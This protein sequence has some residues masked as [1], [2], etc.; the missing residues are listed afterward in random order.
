VSTNSRKY[1]AN[2]NPEFDFNE[3]VENVKNSLLNFKYKKYVLI[4]SADVYSNTSDP[5]LSCEDSIIEVENLSRYGFHKYLAEL[6]VK[7]YASDWL[8]FRMGGFI[9]LGLKKNAIFDILNNQSMWIDPSSR[10]QFMNTDIAGDIVLTLAKNQKNQI[11][12]LCG[13]GTVR[14]SD[15][16]SILRKEPEIITNPRLIHHEVSLKKINRLV[17]I[18][19]SEEMVKSYLTNYAKNE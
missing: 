19:D 1:I 14:L 8:I 18:P 3:T 6:L 12:N 11:F 17:H 13:N 7:N 4:S 9:G 10:L 15:V 16:I 5:K 2:E